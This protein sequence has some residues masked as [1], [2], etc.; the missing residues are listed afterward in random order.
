MFRYRFIALVLIPVFILTNLI[1][2]T[3]VSAQRLMAFGEMRAEG[4]VKMLSSTGEWVKLK[5]VYPL[6]KETKLR[7]GEGTVFITTRGGSRIDL[8]KDTEAIVDVTNSTY[9]VDILNCT[10]NVS[11]NMAITEVLKVTAPETPSVLVQKTDV[12]SPANIQGTVFNRQNG[13]EIKSILGKIYVSHHGLKPETLNT[14]D[15]LFVRGECIAAGSVATAAGTPIAGAGVTGEK[16]A[17]G[18]TLAVFVTGA[19]LVAFKAFRGDKVA[20]PAVP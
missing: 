7:I 20:S 5:G 16:I 10:G 8:L 11:F 19:T 2:A 13:T 3:S 12:P 9:A 6:L 18:F 14:G 15:S 1:P 4:E 17:T